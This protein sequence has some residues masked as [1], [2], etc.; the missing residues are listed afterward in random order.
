MSVTT[1]GAVPYPATP[2]PRLAPPGE[3][4]ASKSNTQNS[5]GN[6]A[7]GSAAKE[8]TGNDVTSHGADN[9]PNPGAETEANPLPPPQAATAPGTAQKVNVIA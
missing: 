3:G 6:T 8:A 1:I 2:P 7:V 5:Y 4:Q 9:A